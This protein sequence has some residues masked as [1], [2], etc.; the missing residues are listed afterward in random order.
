MMESLQQLL[1]WLGMGLVGLLI[2]VVILMMSNLF[3]AGRRDK[4]WE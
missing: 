4:D 1:E 2:L 3:T